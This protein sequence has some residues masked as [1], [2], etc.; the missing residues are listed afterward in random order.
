MFHIGREMLEHLH[1]GT[2]SWLLPPRF[3]QVMQYREVC[4]SMREIVRAVVVCADDATKQFSLDHSSDS[5]I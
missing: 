2:L 3:K 5:Y 1:M 4:I